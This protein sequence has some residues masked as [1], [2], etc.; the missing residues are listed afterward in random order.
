MNTQIVIGYD[1]DSR[2]V[3]I[4]IQFAPVSRKIIGTF[5]KTGKLTHGQY[6]WEI[7]TMDSEET[8]QDQVSQSHV[9]KTV[10]CLAYGANLLVCSP[11][12]VDF[13]N[14]IFVLFNRV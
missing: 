11:D 12:E 14:E 5:T 2:D 4:V 3:V 13:W 6:H 9:A 7:L 10:S 8:Q 1:M